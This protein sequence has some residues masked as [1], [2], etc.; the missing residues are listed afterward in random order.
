MVVTL[1]LQFQCCGLENYEDF[2]R[3]DSEWFGEG[4]ADW[5]TPVSC[6]KELPKTSN[7]DC[8]KTNGHDAAHNNFNKVSA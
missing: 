3:G 7:F 8:A 6:C 2:K 1:V 4:K 5:K